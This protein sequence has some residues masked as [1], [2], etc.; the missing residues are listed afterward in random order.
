MKVIF[1]LLSFLLFTGCQENPAPVK[2]EISQTPL[3]ISNPTL[4]GA[5]GSVGS[6]APHFKGSAY[7]RSLAV[8]RALDELAMQMGVQVNVVA[9]REETSNGENVNSKSDIQTEQTVKNSDVT[10][11]IEATYIDPKTNELFV[12]MILN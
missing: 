10:A 4:N 7:Q 9:K 3:W 8:S 11:H 1:L 12:W 2:I 6:S 5:K